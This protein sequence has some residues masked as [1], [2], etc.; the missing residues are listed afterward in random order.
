MTFHVVYEGP[1]G[2]PFPV[3]WAHGDHPKDRWRWDQVHNPTPLTPLAQD[4]IAIK[5]QG[6]YRGGDITGRPFHEE[7][8]Y[9]NGY[10]FSRSLK[11]DPASDELARKVAERDHLLRVDRIVELWE[12]SYRPETEALTRSLKH[13]AKHWATPDDTLSKLLS[14]YDQV[15]AAWRR[16]GEL[17]TI[18][19]GLAS[20]AMREFDEFCNEKFGDEGTRIAVESISGMP[21]MSV[22]SGKALWELSRQVISHPSV[23]DLIRT[24][25][26]KEFMV[27][28]DLVPEGLEFRQ[29]LERF[30]KV[31]GQRNES[32]YEVGFL[33]WIEGP[34]FVLSTLRT[35]INSP[36]EQS[37]SSLHDRAI[38]TRLTRTENVKSR[39]SN[40]EDLDRFLILQSRAQQYTVLMEDHN[41]YIDQRAYTSLRTPHQAIG[42]AMVDD[43][44]L[45]H[46]ND[47]FY[48]HVQ[49]IK[50]HANHMDRKYQSL[51][52]ERVAERESWMHVL[53]PGVIGG[54]APLAATTTGSSAVGRDPSSA[55][56]VKGLSASA[57]T[58]VGTARVILSLD[59]SNRLSP[60]EILVTYATAPPWTPLFAVAA[61]VVTDA[62]GP[63]A[64]CAVVAREYGIPAIVGAGNAT[65]A[66]EDGMTIRV[67]GTTGV[68]TVQE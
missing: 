52:A 12:T 65:S 13:W 38:K 68:V 20:V 10:G 60:G 64:H 8:M 42:A 49:E 15:E 34:E 61:A 19:T 4:M 31:W 63:L 16:C 27:D 37:P 28:L 47:V 25:T 9:A 14:R 29:E 62:G 30:L 59:D 58:V 55:V 22:E 56:S 67:D 51:V 39:L 2:V 66:I 53:P 54:D 48:L 44:A 23:A 40:P 11:G 7:R 26:S 35:Y 24:R 41:Y 3:D 18:S 50:D 5:R 33:T 32:Y 21:N 43:G 6:M 45:E 17:H 57:G 36:E 1:G 46:A